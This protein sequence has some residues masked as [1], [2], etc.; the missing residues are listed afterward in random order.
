[1]A[2]KA[3]KV[4]FGD[5]Q[6]PAAL[7]RD[8]CA[9]LAREARPASIIEPSCGTGAFLVAALSR[10][11]KAKRALGFE[12]NPRY[13]EAARKALAA[14]NADARAGVERMDF[15]RADWERVLQGL[16]DPL[17]II[18]N[19]PWVTNAALGRLGSSNLPTKSN[20]LGL[21][22][23]DAMT[24]KSNF[25]ISEWMILNHLHWIEGRDATLAML[26]KTT[27]ARKVLAY[28]WKNRMGLGRASIYAIDAARHFGAA[29][30]AC[31]LVCSSTKG[32]RVFDCSVWGA[33]DAERPTHAIGFRDEQ[34]VAKLD[35][36]HRW[37][38]L[39]GESRRRWRSGPK[40]DCS[41]VMEFQKEGERYRNGLGELVELEGRY[42]YPMLKSSELANGGTRTP[43]RWMLVTQR[44]VGEDT[45]AIRE[46]APK[47][48]K[49]LQS[50]AARLDRRR[51]SI[52]RNRPRFSM[53]AVGPYTF[54]PW[55]VAI[56]GFYK[57]L[58]FKTLGGVGSKPI[59]L[60]DTCYFLPF[61]AERQA[62]LAAD[63][64]NSE[65]AREFLNA[66][67]FWDAKRPI[68]IDV[69]RRIDLRALALECGVA[70]EPDE[71]RDVEN[72]S[73]PGRSAL[74]GMAPR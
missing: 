19:P 39:S 69:L 17:L 29:V 5:F 25:D 63:L 8:V 46:R 53:F 31:L 34:I 3:A 33:I 40:H 18:G 74:P 57:K 50:H 49:Y 70:L 6:T 55:K 15:F 59:L 56:S 7:A 43:K 35:L 11:P 26:C 28:G 13:V 4:E 58:D 30:D 20:F 65:P 12:I 14:V 64:L 47:T 32:R 66:F 52:Y 9:L 51:S 54:S 44:A 73:P 71:P 24:G 1:M 16:P 36:Y 68:T 38:R 27:V 62:R 67:I 23:M 61:R 21:G 60:D 10:F 42:M 2:R 22:G 48:W 72:L 41:G 45:S 37:K